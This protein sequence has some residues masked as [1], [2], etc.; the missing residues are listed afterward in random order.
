MRYYNKSKTLKLYAVAG[1]QTV[2]LSFDIDKKKLDSKQFLGF[3]IERK[4][5]SGKLVY[6]NG[7]KR[8]PSLKDNPDEK[9]QKRSYI[10]SFYWQDYIAD[11]D[12]T[13]TYTVR[14]MFG[15]AL[16][17]EEKY[18]NSI[19]ITTE[20]LHDGEH[21]VFFNYGVTGSQS[22]ARNFDNKPLEDMKG[23]ELKK[24]EAYL[25]RDLWA[26]GL[27]KFVRQAT[28]S[29]Y[30]IYGCFYEFHFD[31]FLKELKEAKKRK[32]D[33]Q[34]IVS[35]KPEQYD[36][37][38][39]KRSGE[40]KHGNHSMIKKFGLTKN[41]KT[42]RTKPS[43]PHNKFMILCKN[44]EPE[45][46]WTGS[47]NITLP[48]IFGQCNSGHWINK[49]SIAKKYMEYW[50][51]LLGDP[52][53]STLAKKVEAIQPDA[54][55]V[56]L[57]KGD[58]VFFS[59]RDRGTTKKPSEH[60]KNYADLIDNA[61][62]LV[63]MVFPFNMDD[64]FAEVY[65]KDKTYLRLLLFE[66]PSKASKVKSNDT[67]LKVTAGQVYKGGVEKNWLKEVTAKKT[68]KAGILYVHNKFFILD[69]LTDHPVVVT[70]SANFSNNSI[71]NNDEN[72]L[73]IK[74]NARVADIYLTEFD[75]LFVHFWP[76]YL[77]ELLKKKKP[78]K[79]FDS[80]LDETGTWHKDYFDKDKFGMKRKLLFNN[81]HG[82]KKG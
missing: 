5:K 52:T 58:Y 66:S 56:Q 4:D 33:V 2:L 59:P 50:N 77:R 38:V 48:G 67:D 80:P 75:R 44:G 68:T 37:K 18:T 35:G 12:E 81:M 13:Y 46:V 34:L 41:I 8:F 73:L 36:D 6:L 60:L 70:G 76:R 15:T 72:S 71:R 65:K 10:Q 61:N 14:P 19:T 40:L 9:I 27:L 7:S 79:G 21:S 63:C 23:K 42:L 17:P 57:P 51:S 16:N 29:S 64:V 31:G 28:N 82:A 20:K 54:D 32:V 55:L 30:S 62:G 43:Q 74:G 25:G 26:E 53:M 11:P 45:Q 69:A 1:T 47:T 78:K 22:Y 24:A 3:S 49:K 39:D